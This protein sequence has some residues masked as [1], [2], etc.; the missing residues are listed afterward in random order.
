MTT[1]D[2]IGICFIGVLLVLLIAIQIF[3]SYKDKSKFY[4]ADELQVISLSAKKSIEYKRRSATY[5]LYR[6]LQYRMAVLAARGERELSIKFVSRRKYDDVY[7]TELLEAQ[8]YRVWV[9][10]W[11]FDDHNDFFLEVRW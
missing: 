6:H 1:A 9:H 5:K 3:V 2:I 8:G 7:L 10:F 11:D 4:S